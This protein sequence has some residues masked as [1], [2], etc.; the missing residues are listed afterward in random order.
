[1]MYTTIVYMMA[2]FQYSEINFNKNETKISLAHYKE[3]HNFTSDNGVK[4]ALSWTLS[5]L[6]PIDLTYGDIEVQQVISV[7]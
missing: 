7:P 1:M 4:F 5:D 3:I 2:V 6:S